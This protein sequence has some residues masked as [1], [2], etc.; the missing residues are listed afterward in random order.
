[1]GHL[2]FQHLSQT[3]S[4]VAIVTTR[5]TIEKWFQT[6]KLELDGMDAQYI[7]NSQGT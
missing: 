2:T 4:H 7:T 3:E 1:M 5:D 6:H